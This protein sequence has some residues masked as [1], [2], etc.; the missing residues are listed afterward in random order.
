VVEIEYSMVS[1]RGIGSLW[2]VLI[3]AVLAI[4]GW[5]YYNST[6]ISGAGTNVLPSKCVANPELAGLDDATI[7]LKTELANFEDVSTRCDKYSVSTECED[8]RVAGSTESICVWDKS[9]GDGV[10]DAYMGEQC[11]GTSNFGERTCATYGFAN[12]KLN[13]RFDCKVDLTDCTD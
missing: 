10:I 7:R 6:N 3:V 2:I 4:G 12:G 1:K 8:W 13:C 5:Y 11:E 9:C